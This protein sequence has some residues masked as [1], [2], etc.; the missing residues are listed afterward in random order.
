MATYLF[1]AK[2]VGIQ[3]LDG[4]SKKHALVQNC[5]TTFPRKRRNPRQ[6]PQ[7]IWQQQIPGKWWRWG[8][9]Q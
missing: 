5:G 1:G 3:S 7:F 8:E 2:K 6:Q 4:E 9:I